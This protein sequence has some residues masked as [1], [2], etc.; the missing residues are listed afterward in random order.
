LPERNAIAIGD[1]HA[2][3]RDFPHPIGDV[4]DLKDFAAGIDHEVAAFEIRAADSRIVWLPD[5]L[6][7][8]LPATADDIYRVAGPNVADRCQVSLP[9]FPPRLPAR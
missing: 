6:A 3:N 2:G 1:D 8:L 7:F 4:P 9:F 5:N